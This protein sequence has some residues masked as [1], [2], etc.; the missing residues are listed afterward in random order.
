[1]NRWIVALDFT[2]L[3]NTILKYT[4]FFSNYFLPKE[5]HFV[6]IQKEE[7]YEYLPANLLVLK[8]Q[9]YKD[10]E[11]KLRDKVE[12]YFSDNRIKKHFHVLEGSVVYEILNL[13]NYYRF[14]LLIMGKKPSAEGMGFATDRL[15]KKI[16]SH[17]LI[18]PHDANIKLE[19]IL[20]PVDFSAHAQLAFNVAKKLYKKNTAKIRLFT[21]HIFKVPF[22]YSMEHT[23]IE[24]QQIIENYARKKMAQFTN[25]DKTIIESYSQR[26]GEEIAKQLSEWI[27][28]EKIDLVVCGS[29][30][31]TKRSLLMLGSN[32]QKMIHKISGSPLLIIKEPEENKNFF[33]SMAEEQPDQVLIK[34][35][36]NE[37]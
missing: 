22:E 8:K 23:E 27:L 26:G 28:K 10:K 35:S 37:I 34:K 15:A 20:I 14:D 5:I 4:S 12:Q 19:K 16:T 29:K 3:D 21:H 1:M 13:D 25:N 30:G 2:S 33:N 18:I 11:L 36:G 31:Q 6:N 7:D 9:V 24:L 17:V 32:V